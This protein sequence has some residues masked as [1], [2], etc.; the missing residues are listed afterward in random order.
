MTDVATTEAPIEHVSL[1]PDVTSEVETAPPEA[2]EASGVPALE[3]VLPKI[4]HP[5]GAVRQAVL[6]HLLD[7]EGPQTVAQIIAGLGNHSRGT[8]ETSIKREFDAG[9]IERVAPGTYALAEPKPAK[10]SPPPPPPDEAAL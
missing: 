9:R 1:A 10:P 7:S 2:A 3:R 8:V 4:E 5:I 6:D